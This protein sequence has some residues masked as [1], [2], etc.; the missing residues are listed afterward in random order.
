MHT[1]PGTHVAK[2]RRGNRSSLG[3]GVAPFSVAESNGSAP[4]LDARP[5]RR[6]DCTKM[7]HRR[8]ENKRVPDR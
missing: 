2:G 4:T 7:Q 1:M 5:D 6:P 3:A 8:D